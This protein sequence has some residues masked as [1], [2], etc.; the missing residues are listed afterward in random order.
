[1][2]HYE[3]THY[4]TL[5]VSRTA[6][7]EVIE[8][9]WKTLMRMHHPDIAK[10]NEDYAKRL[11]QA[12]EV[13]SDPERRRVYDE[14]LKPRHV[15]MPNAPEEAYPPAY[16]GIRVPRFDVTELYEEVVDAIDLPGV[17]YRG[18]EEAGK[19]VLGKIIRE[20]PIIGQVLDQAQFKAKERRK[21]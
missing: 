20:N 12:H 5:Q 2:T 17:L 4:E 10:G 7:Q 3:T 21:K 18:L 6:S 19:R 13:L 16:R 1:M 11:N 15:R 14:T 8:V 9:A